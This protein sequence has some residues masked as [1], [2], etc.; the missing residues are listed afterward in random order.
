MIEDVMPMAE[1]RPGSL[2]GLGCM[3]TLPRCRAGFFASAKHRLQDHEGSRS[4]RQSSEAAPW[5][6]SAFTAL[7]SERTHF[8]SSAAFSWLTGSFGFIRFFSEGTWS[9]R[10]WRC[11][12]GAPGSICSKEFLDGGAAG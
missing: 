10:G 6:A 5:A 2:A 3:R 12:A 4:F 1:K 11:P 7:F 8:A 9:A